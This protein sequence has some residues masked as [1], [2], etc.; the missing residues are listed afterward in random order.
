MPWVLSGMLIGLPIIF[1]SNAQQKTMLDATTVRIGTHDIAFRVD[2]T[3]SRPDPKGRRYVISYKGK[4]Y[5]CANWGALKSF[6]SDI[7][8]IFDKADK[9]WQHKLYFIYLFAYVL[10]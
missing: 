4:L 7:E 10:V 8:S 1:P 2:A 3:R 9:N 5:I 6:E